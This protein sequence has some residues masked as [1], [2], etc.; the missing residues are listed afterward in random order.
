MVRRLIGGSGDVVNAADV[1]AVS[2]A[3]A[4]CCDKEILSGDD[5]VD[6]VNAEASA[7]EAV[8]G[9]LDRVERRLVAVEGELSRAAAASAAASVRRMR[10]AC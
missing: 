7:D 4:R 5:G 8:E 3:M 10:D 1:C 2:S 9:R 6:D